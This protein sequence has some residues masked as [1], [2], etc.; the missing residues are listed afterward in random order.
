[1]PTTLL[2][3][4]RAE[5]RFRP[6]HIEFQQD[7]ALPKPTSQWRPGETIVD[8]PYQI[9]VPAKTKSYDLTIGLYQDRRVLLT[10]VERDGNRIL[11]ARLKVQQQDGKVTNI[12]ADKVRYDPHA[13]PRQGPDF[14]VRINPPGTWID[15]GRLA[16]DAAV[17]INRQADRLVLFPY[18]REKTFRVA[19]DVKGLAPAANTSAIQVHALEAGSGQ[20]LGSRRIADGGR[21]ADVDRRKTRGGAIRDYLEVKANAEFRENWR[22]WPR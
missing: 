8:G 11:L 7:H 17:K 20:D 14:D 10:G 16:T 18:P 13:K 5:R 4:C 6:N 1:M 19:L 15:F 9:R 3:S 2:R 21:A 12:T 22:G